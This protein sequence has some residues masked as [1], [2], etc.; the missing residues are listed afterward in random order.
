MGSAPTVPAGEESFAELTSDIKYIIV[1]ETV[2][3]F[4]SYSFKNV[5]AEIY[6]LADGIDV[7]TSAFDG[8]SNLQN[9]NGEVHSLSTRSFARSG[10]ETINL[11]D[12][13]KYIPQAAFENSKLKEIELPLN[14]EDI[15]YL[16]LILIH[17]L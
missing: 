15:Q 8:A 2:R 13:I 7:G 11:C 12:D 14:L 4:D 9:F 16:R 5:E 17:H 3:K 1:P 6:I 10:I